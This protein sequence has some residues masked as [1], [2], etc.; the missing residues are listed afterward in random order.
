MENILNVQNISINFGGLKAIDGVDFAVSH[1]EILAIIGP[2]GAGKTTV[3]NLI[4]GLYAPTAGKIIYKNQ[5]IG[6]HSVIQRSK[7]GIARTFQN[8]RLAKNLTVLENVLVAMK[9][10]QK[11]PVFNIFHTYK[12]ITKERQ[13]NRKKAENLISLVG[14][15]EKID[16]LAGNLS[17][18][19]QRFVEI[20]RALATDCKLI[21]MDEPA[22]GIN[23]ADRK[24]LSN[25]ISF[26]S[27]DLNISV[28]LIEHDL[29]FVMN[30][31]DKVVVLDHG[32]KIGEGI[33]SEIRNN[34]KVIEAYIGK[35]H[36]KAGG[37]R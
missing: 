17:Y 28:I 37:N 5:D 26:I 22:A 11:E 35:K 10:V 8:I 3:F 24:E 9:G 15:S 30:I 34:E 19:E 18:G 2:N 16:V 7:I 4:T 14:L 32:K 20:A 23:T 27:R 33:P 12:N 6:K 13:K 29:E 31:A 1:G 21:L 25:T 36:R